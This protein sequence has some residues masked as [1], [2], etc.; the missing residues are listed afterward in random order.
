M[1]SFP[2]ISSGMCRNIRGYSRK[3]AANLLVLYSE[4][5][6][7]ISFASLLSLICWGRLPDAIHLP[8]NFVLTEGMT[9][10]CCHVT[11]SIL[12]KNLAFD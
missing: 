12:N 2:V 8:S 5:V 1:A 3:K 10:L 11:L 6:P 4:Q 7:Q 9:I